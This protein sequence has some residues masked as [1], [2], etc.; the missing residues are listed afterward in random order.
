MFFEIFPL[1]FLTASAEVLG[2][3]GELN[4]DKYVYYM[5]SKVNTYILFPVFNQNHILE[6]WIHEKYNCEWLWAGS[7]WML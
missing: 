6:N 4:V 7:V 5:V 1:L 3:S 2:Q